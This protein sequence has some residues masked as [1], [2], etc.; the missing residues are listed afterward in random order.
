MAAIIIIIIIII[1]NMI[2]KTMEICS[3]YRTT[4]TV[5]LQ[6]ACGR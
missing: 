5:V 2:S 3:V 6:L 1:N 4:R